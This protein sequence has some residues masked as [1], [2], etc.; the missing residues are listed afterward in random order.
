MADTAQ[1]TRVGGIGFQHRDQHRRH[2]DKHGDA[3]LLDQGVDLGRIEYLDQQDR[4][5]ARDRTKRRDTARC[6]EHRGHYNRPHS[7]FTANA[8]QGVQGV[9]GDALMMQDNALR[10]A[11]GAGGIL[12][13]RRIAGVH[14]GQ[15]RHGPS[16]PEQ[17][18][19]VGHVD[20]FADGRNLGGDRRADLGNRIAAKL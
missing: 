1:V 13:L 17:R 18:R 14:F 9:V 5:A 12:D 19:M 10:K 15:R 8:Q 6:M 4:M 7:R 11:R 2:R 20:H 16:L 3:F